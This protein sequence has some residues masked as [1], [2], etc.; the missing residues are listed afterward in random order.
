MYIASSFLFHYMKDNRFLARLIN[1][2]NN[3]DFYNHLN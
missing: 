2:S 3:Y 1:Y